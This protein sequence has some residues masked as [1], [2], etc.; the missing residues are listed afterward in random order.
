MGDE[1]RPIYST[2]ANDESLGEAIDNFIVRVSDRIDALQ[3][4]EMHGDFCLVGS[5][6]ETLI[7]ESDEVG[8]SPLSRSATVIAA[9]AEK[10]SA[11]E[12]HTALVELT[13]IARRIR[14]GHRGS[15]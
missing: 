10:Q 3:D 2:R 15:V 7:R 1:D 12:V 6:A 13:E 14:L 4:A 11:E 8:F 5:L 9:S